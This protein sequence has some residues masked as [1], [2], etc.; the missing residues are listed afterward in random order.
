MNN[1]IKYIFHPAYTNAEWM[2]RNP[3]L[4]DGEVACIKDASGRVTNSKV[5]P[6]FYNDLPLFGGGNYPYADAVTNEIGDAKGI[7][8]GKSAFEIIRLMLNPYQSPVMSAGRN[9]A[10]IVGGAFANDQV[11]EIGVALS[12]NLLVQYNVSAAYNLSGATPINV[13]SL[14]VFNDGN[15]AN[16]QITLSPG[17]PINPTMVTRVEIKLKAL[18]TNGY[19]NIISTY[20]NWWPRL[21][22]GSS[23][24]ADLTSG[25]DVNALLSKGTIL[26][27]TPNHDYQMSRVGYH[28]IAIPG[29]L[30]PN[31]PSFT[32]ITD[33][34]A[35]A[36]VGFIA[37]GS[38]MVNNG[39][40]NYNY[41]LYR[42]PFYITESLS[43]YRVVN[44]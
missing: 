10:G 1:R 7:L 29:I 42:S 44:G 35:P 26:K 5:G 6:G 2:Q 27:N 33:P 18:H 19:S 25:S 8:Y 39:V 34:N 23:E 43:K 37:K 28:W 14:G 12:G 38:M 41:Q 17:V 22:W 21:I 31:N 32:D 4:G 11:K 30:S 24:L 20:V 15:F 9:N 13:N 40:G 16:G 36:N 3:L